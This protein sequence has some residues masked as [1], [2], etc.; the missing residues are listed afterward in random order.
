VNQCV[1]QYIHSFSD[2]NCILSEIF[3]IKGGH[4]FVKYR[5][6]FIFAKMLSKTVFIVI[7]YYILFIINGLDSSQS[8]GIVYRN[9]TFNPINWY[10]SH[11]SNQNYPKSFSHKNLEIGSHFQIFC[12]VEKGSYPCL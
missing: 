9:K 1:A 11:N 10:L 4:Y 8:T 3:N 2:L 12:T 7:Y 5:Y 6:I